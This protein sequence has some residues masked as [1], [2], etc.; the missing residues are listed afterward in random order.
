MYTLINKDSHTDARRGTVHTPHGDVPTPFFMPVATT[1]TVKTMSSVD[2]HDM[3][4]PIVLS[5]TYHLYLRPGLEIMKEAGGLHKFMNWSKPILTDSGGYQAFSL[6]KKFSKTTD[7]GVHFQS[8]IDGSKH[9][10]TPEL[11]MDIQNILGSDMVMPLDECSP[12][13]CEYKNAL[14]G[15]KRTTLWAKRCKD[16][17]HSTG[18]H[19]R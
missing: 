12:H 1:A 11:V 5:N 18:M 14:K 8:H 7:E 6:S 19:A 3:G 10:F 13:P 2:L 4:S 17:F 16:H 9:L 15:L